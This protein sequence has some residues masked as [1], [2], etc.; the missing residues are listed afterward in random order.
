MRPLETLTAQG[1]TQWEG[2]TNPELDKRVRVMTRG[3]KEAYAI[4]NTFWWGRMA[5]DAER[6]ALPPSQ[7]ITAPHPSTMNFDRTTRKPQNEIIAYI[8]DIQTPIGA[9]GSPTANQLRQGSDVLPL[10]RDLP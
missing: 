8:R 2:G 6:E 7:R 5:Y 4:S 10:Y 3:G 9:Q 1:W